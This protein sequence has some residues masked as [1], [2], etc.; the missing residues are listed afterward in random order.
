VTVL[1]PVHGMSRAGMSRAGID[2]SWI[3]AH[4]SGLLRL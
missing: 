1:E 4:T 3:F 2:F